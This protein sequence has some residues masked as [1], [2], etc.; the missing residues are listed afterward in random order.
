MEHIPD[1]LDES[2]DLAKALT[3]MLAPCSAQPK[4]SYPHIQLIED[5]ARVPPRYVQNTGSSSVPALLDIQRAHQIPGH[6]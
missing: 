2:S 4:C 5:L 3:P 6:M 1:V